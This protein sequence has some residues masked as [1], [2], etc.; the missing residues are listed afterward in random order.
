MKMVRKWD[1]EMLSAKQIEAL[2][3]WSNPY[4]AKT[5]IFELL[6]TAEA[7]INDYS[8]SFL[9]RSNRRHSPLT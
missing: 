3:E 4:P 7:V 1:E 8:R 6:F 5:P 2:A 9:R